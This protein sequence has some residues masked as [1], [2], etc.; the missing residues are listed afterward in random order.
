MEKGKRNMPER[1]SFKDRESW[2]RWL[3]DN[4]ESAAELWLVLYKVHSGKPS[5][6]LAEAVEEALCFGWIDGK[7]RRIDDEKHEIRF[8]PRRKG[9][10]WSEINIDRVKRLTKEGRMTKAGL[11]KFKD[12][13]K[14]PRFKLL[15]RDFEIP[16]FV[17]DGLK[18]NK[19]AWREFEKLAPSGKKQYV[20]YIAS[21]KRE[22]TRRRRIVDA[23]DRLTSGKHFQI[24]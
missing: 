23:I 7:L 1:K 15:R 24:A 13:E 9:S 21:A 4:H 8:C 5:I 17:I 2:H 6:R 22:E 18:A 11:D 3:K 12:V 16:Q 14:D 10:V 20:W 19:K